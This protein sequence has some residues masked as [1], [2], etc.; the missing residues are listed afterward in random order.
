[1]RVHSRIATAGIEEWTRRPRWNRGAASDSRRQVVVAQ[2][3]GLDLALV[4]R[5]DDQESPWGLAR[6]YPA[7]PAASTGVR[8]GAEIDQLGLYW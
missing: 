6:Q 2:V 7:D 1:M 4:R 8:A 5:F 3:G